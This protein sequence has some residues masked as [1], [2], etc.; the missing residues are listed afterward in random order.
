MTGPCAFPFSYINIIRSLKQF[1]LLL[2]QQN[3]N[4]NFVFISK[5]MINKNDINGV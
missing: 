4:Y 5:R 3:A 2:S 1:L